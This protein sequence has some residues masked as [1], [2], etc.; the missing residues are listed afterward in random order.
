MQQPMPN[1]EDI[2]DPTTAINM[3][4]VLM[5]KAFKL[6]YSTPTNNNH[7]ISSNPRNRQIAQPGMNL[8]QNRQMQMVGGNVQNLGIQNLGN[9]NGLIVVLRIAN[10]NLNLNMNGNVVAA[11]AKGNEIE[12][13][14]DLD[15]IKEVNT[16]CILMANLQQAS[17]S[18]TQTDKAPVYDSN[19]SA[20]K[21]QLSS[22]QE[23]KKKL[24]SDFKIREDKLLVVKLKKRNVDENSV[25]MDMDDIETLNIEL[26]HRVTKLVTENEHLKQTYKQLYDSIKPKRV[27]S[28]EQCDALIKQVN[29]KSGEI[30]DL[31]AKLQEQDEIFPIVNQVDARL[32]NFEIQFLKK[33][34]KFVRDFKSLTKEANESLA[35]H[36]ALEFEIEHLLRAVVSQDI[37]SIVQNNSTVDTS[38]LQIELDQTKEKLENC[39]IKKKK[40]YVV[41]WNNWYTKCEECK[42]EIR[43][44]MESLASVRLWEFEIE[45]LRAGVESIAKT[46]RPQPRNNTKNDR[47]SSASKSS[48]IT[49]KE[50]EVEEHHKNLLLSNNQ[51]LMSSESIAICVLHSRP[52]HHHVVIDK[53]PYELINSRK[54]DISFLQVFGALYYHK[55]G[56]KDIGK[57]GAKA[58]LL[59]NV[60]Q[61]PGFKALTLDKSFQGHRSS[62][63]ATCQLFHL[64]NQLNVSWI[65]SSKLLYDD[66]IGGGSNHQL[67]P[68]TAS[69]TTSAPQ[70]L[71]T[72]AASTTTLEPQQQHVQQQDNQAL[73]QPKIVA[74]SVPN[75]M[76]DGDVFENPFALPST[77][78]AE[79]S[80]S[81]Y[82]RT[83][84]EM[85]IYALTVSIKEPRNVKEAMT[86]PACDLTHCEYGASTGSKGLMSMGHDEENTVIRNK[87]R[88]V[89]RGYCQEEGIDFEE[90]FTSVARMEAIRIFLAY[91]AYKSFIV[92]QMDVK[93][94]FL[95]AK[96]GTLWV[97]AST[98][99]M[100]QKANVSNIANQT[101]LKPKVR[102]PNQVG[103][104]ERL[105]SPKPSQPR[106]Y[107]RWSPTGRIFD[108]KGKIIAS[109]KS[110][111]QSD[112]SVDDNACTSNPQEPIRKQFPKSTFSLTGRPNLFMVRP[113]RV[114]RAYDRKSE[115]SNKLCLEVLR[116]RPL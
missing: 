56:H 16:N 96:E 116:N 59:N 33:V 98:E 95:H 60:F 38:N 52:L 89:V 46:R 50:V 110:E 73:L 18:G 35:K 74:D 14:G 51:K 85:C 36:K 66:Y 68:R 13:N 11:R 113:H 29:I 43:S 92:F 101:N 69:P 78:A 15:E 61:S 41:L 82:L 81:Q 58:W 25:K 112:V 34:A 19:R 105:A 9:Q 84:G 22:L 2:T 76:F 115:A 104:K 54:P 65:Y 86:D 100:K 63:I 57:L 8:G 39:I 6:N 87:T 67:P 103:S 91:A 83:D 49:N 99:G 64:I 55:N 77:S 31:N 53:T 44:T 102:K 42:Y 107:L 3:T 21:N 24:K 45:C 28:K 48:C 80:S 17:T 62:L 93:T 47:V 10:Q 5:A 106:T 75:A 108:L 23:E 12:N 26:E 109:S 30:S 71:Q 32:Q 79:S 7:I 20:E 90:S 4:L 70:V 88:L 72:T 1:P 111:Y 97:K 94:A 40:E 27:Q 114:L 37:M